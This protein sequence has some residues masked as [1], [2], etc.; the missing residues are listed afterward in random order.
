MAGIDAEAAGIHDAGN[1]KT[2]ELG[3]ELPGPGDIVLEIRPRQ[4]IEQRGDADDRAV[5]PA[6]GFA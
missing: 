4:A 3:E 2:I 5:E 1:S 6:R